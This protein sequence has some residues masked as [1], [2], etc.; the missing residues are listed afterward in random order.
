MTAKEVL[1][2]LVERTLADVKYSPV[3]LVKAIALLDQM[4]QREKQAETGS[5]M[6]QLLDALD[7]SA[8]ESYREEAGTPEEE[9][10]DAANR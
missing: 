4:E 7:R 6:Q 1:Q 9:E 2:A 5:G 8:S 3:D 10:E